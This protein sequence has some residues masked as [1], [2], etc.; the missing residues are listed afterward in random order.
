MQQ[1]IVKER[2]RLTDRQLFWEHQRKAAPALA[3]IFALL[4]VAG[5]WNWYLGSSRL[6]RAPGAC[7]DR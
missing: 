6:Q 1:Q 5:W 7:L 3:V 4:A 2:L